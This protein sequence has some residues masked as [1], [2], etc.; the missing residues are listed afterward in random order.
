MRGM[1]N[2]GLLVL[3]FLVSFRCGAVMALARNLPPDGTPVSVGAALR[4]D[5][6]FLLET[7]ERLYPGILR[8]G[9]YLFTNRRS[10]LALLLRS[11]Q[12]ITELAVRTFFQNH[13]Q[14]ISP[15]S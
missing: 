5:W 1:I 14:F 4:A 13:T 10:L 15:I 6:H 3:I 9:Q 8:A 2:R 11:L 7:A 12:G